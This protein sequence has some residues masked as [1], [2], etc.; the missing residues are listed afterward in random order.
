MARTRACSWFRPR[1]RCHEWRHRGPR[2]LHRDEPHQGRVSTA[3]TATTERVKTHKNGPRTTRNRVAGFRVPSWPPGM[4]PMPIADVPA[5]SVVIHARS[6]GPQ[7]PV[8]VVSSGSFPPVGD[9]MGPP[10]ERSSTRVTPRKLRGCVEC[11]GHLHAA[12][13]C[14]DSPPRQPGS[15]D[16]PK[17]A[18]DWRVRSRTRQRVRSCSIWRSAGGRSPT[19]MSGG[20]ARQPTAMMSGRPDFLT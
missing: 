15:F 8:P 20:R 9:P 3:K 2:R 10:K 7:W 19:R 16:W 14:R 6:P 12:V 18:K 4:L 1:G 11:K 5:R 17:N 13:A